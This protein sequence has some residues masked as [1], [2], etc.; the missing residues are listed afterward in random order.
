MAHRAE[1]RYLSVGNYSQGHTQWTWQ[2]R[3]ASLDDLPHIDFSN[4]RD[5]LMPADTVIIVLKDTVALRWVKFHGARQDGN[6][7]LEPLA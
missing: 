3:Q 5:V 6:F 7:T 2:V 1:L 4:G